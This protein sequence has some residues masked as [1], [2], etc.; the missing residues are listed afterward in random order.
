MK[1]AIIGAGFS[2]LSVAWHLLRAGCEITLFERKGIGAGASGIATG[3]LH[4]YAGEQGRRS[5]FA[6]EGLAATQELLAIAEL[7]VMRG[8]IR[9]VQ[10]EE[11][12]QMFLGHAQNYGDVEPLTD[13][14]FYIT[15]G[16]TIDCPL[17]LQGLWRALKGV[18]LV[19]GEVTDLNACQGF[20]HI[21]VAA[22]AGAKQFP[23]L[24]SLG[25]STL[26]GQVLKARVPEG[27]QLPKASSISK[28]YVALSQDQR[29]CFLG[30]TYERGEVT[31]EPQADVA[32]ADLLPKIS[33][34]FPSAC[35]LQIVECR[36]AFRVTR[37]GHYL[38]IATRVG[39]NTQVGGN[40]WVLTAMGSRGLLY[41][42]YYGKLL[43]SC[44]T[45]E[46]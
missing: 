46:T 11:Q 12:R 26:K 34:F 29:T 33:T 3:L 22:G 10:N 42:A 14:S 28:G 37:V 16:M 36:A 2:G 24:S 43:A 19:L 18:K 15:S 35:D 45:S 4:P 9:H 21:V 27:V 20:D 32:K 23:E 40:I 41:H 7:K 25:I 44:L 8:I 1:V 5:A 13:T 17:Y 39:G 6:T 38:P 31:E 30:S